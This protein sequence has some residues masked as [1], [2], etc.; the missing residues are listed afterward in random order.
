MCRYLTLLMYKFSLSVGP[1]TLRSFFRNVTSSNSWAGQWLLSSELECFPFHRVWTLCSCVWNILCL[2][3]R[4]FFYCIFLLYRHSYQ[5]FESAFAVGVRLESCFLSTPHL[6]FLQQNFLPLV[7][8]ACDQTFHFLKD[9]LLLHCI[10]AIF[11]A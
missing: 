4:V 8:C 5:I 2:I 1:K 6:L 11:R 10:L 3:L 9:F 7:K